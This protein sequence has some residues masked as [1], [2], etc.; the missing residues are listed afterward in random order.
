MPNS[1]PFEVTMTGEFFPENPTVSVNGEELPAIKVL[2]DGEELPF[3]LVS[4]TEITASVGTFVGNPPLIVNSTPISPGGTDGG[5]SNEKFFFD[6]GKIAFNIVADD[7]D[8]LFGEDVE[9]TF[10]TVGLEEGVTL[11]SLGLPSIVFSTPAVFPYPDVN[12][13][14]IRP[15]FET[16]LTDAQLELYQVNFI[17]GI[18]AVT[19][20]D[21]LIRPED[22]SIFMVKSSLLN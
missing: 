3:T 6:E 8:V 1:V 13:Y 22:D 18:F 2:F 21:L 9:F 10:T 19:K 20:R 12:N 5:D 11:E 4:P 7:V 14:A 17:D 16:P 15:N